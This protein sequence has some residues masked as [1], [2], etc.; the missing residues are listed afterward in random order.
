MKKHQ[1][2]YTPVLGL[3]PAIKLKESNTHNPW[4]FVNCEST[5]IK[6]MDL[7]TVDGRRTNAMYDAIIDSGGLHDYFDWQGPFILSSIAPDKTIRGL[8]PEMYSDII[9]ST[10]ADYYLTPD[11]ET[12]LNDKN[13]L[14]FSEIGRVVEETNYLIDS[15]PSTPI[16][17]VK[18]TNP[19]QIVY[20]IDQLLE[21]DIN[22]YCFHS[23]EFTRHNNCISV[24]IGQRLFEQ[25]RIR[26]PYLIA[27]GVGTR[28]SI[29]QYRAA[30]AFVTQSHF[31]NRYNGYILKR[32]CSY[33][34]PIHHPADRNSIMGNLIDIAN[35]VENLH[36]NQTTLDE[37]F[38]L[39]PEPYREFC[40]SRLSRNECLLK[41]GV[42]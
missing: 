13:R 19:D 32:G 16:G 6:V 21:L 23:S 17:L 4:E 37:F 42:K 31:T 12:Y 28:K 26:V 40:L 3:I 7:I 10:G 30:D 9:T 24:G 2:N 39:T 34:L 36:K 1:E 5:V 41:M 29:W 18:G 27:Y 8:V 35:S 25:I 14:S 38:T 33:K 11:G 15:T 20:H 22:Q